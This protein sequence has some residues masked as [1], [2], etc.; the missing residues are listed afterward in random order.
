MIGVTASDRGHRLRIT[1]TP[2]RSVACDTAVENKK[3]EWSHFFKEKILYRVSYT[4]IDRLS[5]QTG[6]FPRL[7]ENIEMI[8]LENRN[9]TGLK[10]GKSSKLNISEQANKLTI[11]L[12]FK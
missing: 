12:T 7:A 9:F 3:M 8:E 1:H 5:R 2:R 6:R 10:S 11:H 4:S